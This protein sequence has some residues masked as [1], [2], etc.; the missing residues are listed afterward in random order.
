MGPIYAE[1]GQLAADDLR[2]DPEGAF[3]YAEVE[4]G[5]IACSIFKDVGDRVIY[6]HCSSALA[7]KLHDAWHLVAPDKRWASLSYTISGGRFSVSFQFPEEFDPEE[8]FSD[9]R[10]R[11]LAEKF[12]DKPIDYS[13]P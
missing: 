1:I 5:A 10:P 13:D 4:D 7:L 12:G 3:L 9:R 6:R 8:D 11:V 2:A